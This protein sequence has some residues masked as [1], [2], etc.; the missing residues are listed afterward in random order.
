MDSQDEETEYCSNCKRDIPAINYVMHQTHCVRN[1]VLC[2]KCDEPVPRSEMEAHNEEYHVLELCECGESIEKE[3]FP[4]H[5]ENDCKLRIVKCE[6]CELD[7]P[8]EKLVEHSDFC[9]SRTEKCAKCNKFVKLRDQ[10]IHDLNECQISVADSLFGSQQGHSSSYYQSRLSPTK[11]TATGYTSGISGGTMFPYQQLYRPTVMEELD[12]DRMVGMRRSSKN[13]RIQRQHRKNERTV[14]NF[15]TSGRDE[16]DSVSSTRQQEEDD[17]LFALRL[18]SSISDGPSQFPREVEADTAPFVTPV[19][20][21]SDSPRHSLQSRHLL[22]PRGVGEPKRESDTSQIPCEVCD[23][24]MKPSELLNHQE[25]CLLWYGEPPGHFDNVVEVNDE[26]LPLRP[27]PHQGAPLR[28][29]SPEPVILDPDLNFNN[30]R[31]SPSLRISPTR[32]YLMENGLLPRSGLNADRDRLN[33]Q[34]P[35]SDNDDIMVPCE[36]C[37]A[38]LPI[39]TITFHQAV[40]ESGPQQSWISDDMREY[41][42][43]SPIPE[44]EYPQVVRAR[45]RSSPLDPFEDIPSDSM[46]FRNTPKHQPDPDLNWIWKTEA[47]KVNV[48]SHE[49]TLN[50]LQKSGSQTSNGHVRRREKTL[51]SNPPF[52]QSQSSAFVPTKVNVVSKEKTSKMLQ[53]QKLKKKNAQ[54]NSSS[55]VQSSLVTGSQGRGKNDQSR[56]RNLNANNGKI[57]LSPTSFQMSSEVIRS[58]RGI[59]SRGSKHNSNLARDSSLLDDYEEDNMQN[60]TSV[61]SEPSLSHSPPRVQR[62]RTWE[63]ILTDMKQ[64]KTSKQTNNATVRQ[65]PADKQG[66]KTAQTFGVN[67][68]QKLRNKPSSEG[69][70]LN[71]VPSQPSPLNKKTSAKSKLAQNNDVSALEK[72]SKEHGSPKSTV[73]TARKTSQR[74]MSSS[75]LS[76]RVTPPQSTRGK[77]PSLQLVEGASTSA[78]HKKDNSGLLQP[79]TRAVK[80]SK[81][82][83]PQQPQMDIDDEFLNKIITDTHLKLNSGNRAKNSRADRSGSPSQESGQQRRAS[84]RQGRKPRCANIVANFSEDNDQPKRDSRPR[85]GGHSRGG[86][87][88]ICPFLL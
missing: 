50:M 10:V 40:C 74:S 4:D 60:V 70:F 56:S 7:L 79:Q 51:P 28:D 84:E 63:E 44:I 20:P 83:K 31:D 22:V 12:S 9:G 48:V 62:E 8:F 59:A 68:R 69:G 46:S 17:F 67:S 61:N 66:G 52:L 64:D 21:T 53:Q 75:S 25:Q 11:K 3:H 86:G 88:V 45:G 14:Q 15:H 47:P 55:T 87:Q 39:D 2:K 33:N 49:K 38:Q 6:Y 37:E 16:T 26:M 41:Q 73:Y 1:I 58:T 13:E 85:R 77:K 34:Q 57:G 43:D 72:S 35:V 5:K 71:N 29:P 30:V 24:L 27:F 65:Q 23:Q 36:F 42:F 80:S 32:P 18:A 81:P 54:G 19:H 78:L 82:G 76:S